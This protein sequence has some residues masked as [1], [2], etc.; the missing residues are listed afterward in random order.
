MHSALW[1]KAISTDGPGKPCTLRLGSK[2]ALVDPNGGEAI[3]ETGERVSGDLI[4]GADG[5]HVSVLS[6]QSQLPLRLTEEYSR[7]A[8][9][10]SKEDLDMCHLIAA[11]VL[12]GF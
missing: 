12:F 5:V 1:D 10:P 9:K 7:N 11:S 2:V 4:I 6:L 8:A 3:L